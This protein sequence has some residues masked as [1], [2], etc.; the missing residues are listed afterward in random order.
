[1][2]IMHLVSP[3][4]PSSESD[5]QGTGLYEHPHFSH[6]GCIY[7]HYWLHAYPLTSVFSACVQAL[8][9]Y[10]QMCCSLTIFVVWSLS[11]VKVALSHLHWQREKVLRSDIPLHLKLGSTLMDIV[12]GAFHLQEEQLFCRPRLVK[13]LLAQQKRGAVSS[14]NCSTIC[15]CTAMTK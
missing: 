10:L 14:G 7:R 5:S 3:T 1:M 8:F 11:S 4:A 12:G 13:T 6:T 15:V 2:D 9:Q